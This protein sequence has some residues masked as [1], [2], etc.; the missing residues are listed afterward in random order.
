MN[1]NNC[2]PCKK[3]CEPCGH[4]EPVFSVE[5]MPDDPT[6]LQFNVNGKSVWYDFSPVVKTAETAT[7]VTVDAVNRTL[8]HHGEKSDQ[9]ITAGEL[10]GIL[11]LADIGDVNADTIED[12]GILNYR[13][14]GGCGEGCESNTS[15][16]VSVSPIDVGTG[17]LDYILGSDD[18]G[19]MQSLMPPTDTTKFSTLTW[20][21]GEKAT[22]RT[23][24]VVAT[25]PVNSDGKVYRPYIDPATLELVICL[26][27]A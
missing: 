16:W 12:N 3:H 20:A 2:N 24:T 11:H 15:G 10:G 27:D 6:I 23:P 14:E 1:T 21:A 22:W 25:P 5:A 9:S 7:T 19:L 17:S 4:A 18:D 13:K 8:D 26:E